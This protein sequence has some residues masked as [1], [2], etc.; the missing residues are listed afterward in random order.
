MQNV[1]N[2]LRRSSPV[3]RTGPADGA[4]GEAADAAVD[5]A[6]GR[7]V[8]QPPRMGL[9]LLRENSRPGGP[10]PRAWALFSAAAT[11]TRHGG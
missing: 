3:R 9:P 8:G 7:V 2:Y 10:L 5:R 4:V 11:T 6:V 1:Q